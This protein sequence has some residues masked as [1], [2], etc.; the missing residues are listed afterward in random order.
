MAEDKK[1]FVIKDRRIFADEGK[2][3]EEEIKDEV[4]ESKKLKYVF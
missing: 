4:K 1:D 2:D 3:K